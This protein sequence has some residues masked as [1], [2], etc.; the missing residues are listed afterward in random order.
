MIV[1]V[2]ILL[3]GGIAHGKVTMIQIDNNVYAIHHNKALYVYKQTGEFD[4]Q[5]REIYLYSGMERLQA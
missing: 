4:F 2:S 3:I 5:M 1:A